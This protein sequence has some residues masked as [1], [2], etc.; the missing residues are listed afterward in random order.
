MN[1][2]IFAKMANGSYAIADNNDERL[3]IIAEVLLNTMIR[4]AIKN[5]LLHLPGLA[6][7]ETVAVTTDTTI[8]R[9]RQHEDGILMV[10]LGD[11]QTKEEL[12]TDISNDMLLD[13]IDDW[14]DLLAEKPDEII[15]SRHHDQ[16]IFNLTGKL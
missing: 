12:T 5:K 11:R 8:F 4:S 15:L 9:I 7:G 1:T 13:L 3:L 2:L 16:D 14:E 6:V 10:N